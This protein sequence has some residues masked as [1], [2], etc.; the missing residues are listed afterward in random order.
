MFA[1]RRPTI[2]RDLKCIG[3][4]DTLLKEQDIPIPD[5]ISLPTL[6][7]DFDE[8][9]DKWNSAKNIDTIALKTRT[10]ELKC[11]IKH[12][13]DKSTI[14][15]LTRVKALQRCVNFLIRAFKLSWVDY[16]TPNAIDKKKQQSSLKNSYRKDWVPEKPENEITGPDPAR[17]A[18]YV[19]LMQ[20]IV[21]LFD[22]MVTQKRENL[23]FGAESGTTNLAFII[24][25]CNNV[26]G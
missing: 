15:E 17:K 3:A 7:G 21:S 12:F 26:L 13:Y 23:I 22:W 19:S 5:F 8:W 9:E 16:F 20:V 10:E 4:S 18:E 24:N 14:P 25:T 11:W 1:Q 2:I 6:I